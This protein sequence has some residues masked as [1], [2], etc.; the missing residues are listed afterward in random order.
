MEGVL[1]DIRVRA[2]ARF[3]Q[4]DERCGTDIAANLGIDVAKIKEEV[5]RQQA[6]R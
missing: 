4:A 2:I 6:E 5:K 1:E 3:Y